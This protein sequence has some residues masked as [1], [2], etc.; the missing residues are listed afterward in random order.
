MKTPTIGPFAKAVNTPRTAIHP[1]KSQ[2]ILLSLTSRDLMSA[3]RS[4]AVLDGTSTNSPPSQTRY[5]I[6]LGLNEQR[7]EQ[8]RPDFFTF[9]ANASGSR[10]ACE[11]SVPRGLLHAHHSCKHIPQLFCFILFVIL[12][13]DSGVQS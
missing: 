12:V 2:M 10:P 13:T 3:I 7:H 5:R 9:A 4:S 6:T 11:S 1:H 8:E